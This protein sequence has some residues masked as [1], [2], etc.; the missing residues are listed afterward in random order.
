MIQS[1]FHGESMIADVTV[2]AVMTALFIWEGNLI[3]IL[4]STNASRNSGWT[5]SRAL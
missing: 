3:S 1:T 5:I 2:E 4:R